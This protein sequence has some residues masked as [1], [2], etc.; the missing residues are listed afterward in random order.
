MNIGKLD[1]REWK[2]GSHKLRPPHRIILS[3]VAYPIYITGRLI[4]SLAVLISDLSLSSAIKTY[5][6]IM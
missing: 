5:H 4:V 3:L 6:D 1:L 2:W